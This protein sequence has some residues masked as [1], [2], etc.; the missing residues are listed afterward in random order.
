MVALKETALA[1]QDGMSVMT[2]KQEVI[3]INNQTK[4]IKEIREELEAELKDK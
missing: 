1:M 2:I 4:Q 3:E